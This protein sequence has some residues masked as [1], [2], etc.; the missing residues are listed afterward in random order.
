MVA[1]KG[2][3]DVINSN[4]NPPLKILNLHK[5]RGTYLQCL[6]SHNAKF[7]Y[8]G[9]KTAGVTDCTN[10]APKSVAGERRDGCTDVNCHVAYIST[11]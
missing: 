11:K 2:G 1:F 10:Y 7:V 8:R 9:M 5:I 6:N 3:V 4:F